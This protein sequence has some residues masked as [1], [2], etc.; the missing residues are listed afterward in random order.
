[1]AEE[2]VPESKEEGWEHAP[3]EHFS[4]VFWSHVNPWSCAITFGLRM[5]RPEEK[6]RPTV[7]IRMPLQQGKALAVI[8]LRNIRQ[9]EQQSGADIDLPLQVLQALNIPREDWERFKGV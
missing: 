8:L 4:D 7:R 1:M 9:Y 3:E 2:H 5:T 6:D